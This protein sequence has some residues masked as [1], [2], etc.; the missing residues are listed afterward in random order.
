MTAANVLTVSRLFI[1]FVYFVLL[2]LLPSG[3]LLFIPLV[4][5]AVAGV[6][7]V[8]DG[9]VARRT[10]SVTDFG[11]VADAYIDRVVA[12]GSYVIF[13]SWGLV[14]T[15]VVL[16]IVVRE[17]VIGGMRNL[18]DSRGLKFQAT[19]FGKTKFLS[20]LL[21]CAAVILYRAAF[22]GN[23]SVRTVMDILV[24]LSALNTALS[25]IIYLANYRK[26]VGVEK[27]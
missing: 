17:F 6:T 19:I 12:V 20:Q 5:L 2:I 13:L 25:G 7:D 15:W 23:V 22:E 9:V 8:L 27:T 21:A 14:A 10:N 4:L 16:V 18:A 24:Y 26:L 11:R 1:A 3:P